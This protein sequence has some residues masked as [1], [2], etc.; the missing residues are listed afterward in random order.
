MTFY[1]FMASLEVGLLFAIMALGVYISF[2]VLDFPDLT[3]D[4]SFPL[5]AAISSVMIVSGFDPWL[6]LLIAF[7]GGGLAGLAT[8][9]LSVKLGILNLLASI[10]VMTALYSVNLRIMGRP[11]ISLLG[12]STI[13]TPFED[14]LSPYMSSYYVTP[15]VFLIGLVIVFV[16]LNLFLHTEIGLA[17]RATGNNPHMA[18]AM[19]VNTDRMIMG[20]LALSN[21]LVAFSGALFSQ[22]QGSA[23][24]GMGIG[25]VIAGLVSVIIGETLLRTST[26]F[27]AMLGVC[28]GSL[29][30]R[31]AIGFALSVDTGD[32]WYSFKA[33]DLNFVTALLVVLFLAAPRMRHMLKK[34]PT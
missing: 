5:G 18:R 15:V 33:S 30:Y 31:L 11:N 1:S 24:I 22:A 19:G 16:L 34:D 2:R 6:A 28:V 32:H 13:F 21:G 14:I 17:S 25:T 10:I 20:G 27:L 7:I 23:D 29:V 9:W 3:V 12:E 4:G 26:V 8:A